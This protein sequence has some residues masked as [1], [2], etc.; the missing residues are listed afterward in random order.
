M[1][2]VLKMRKKRFILAGLWDTVMDRT[3]VA[4]KN[5]ERRGDG[6]GK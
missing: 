3:E 2:W 1:R 5:E 4:G 6:I